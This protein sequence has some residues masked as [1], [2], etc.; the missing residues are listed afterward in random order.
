MYPW[1]LIAIPL[2]GSF[3][4]PDQVEHASEGFREWDMQCFEQKYGA[5]LLHLRNVDHFVELVLNAL[6]VIL[7]TFAHFL[8]HSET[9]LHIATLISL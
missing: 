3:V 7:H 4:V 9:Q 1:K 5:Y 6:G 2:L 8:A